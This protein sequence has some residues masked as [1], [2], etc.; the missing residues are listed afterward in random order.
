ME[1]KIT[2][3]KVNQKLLKKVIFGLFPES[4][5]I[6]F[7]NNKTTIKRKGLFSKKHTIN[8][9]EL[10]L[11]SIPNGLNNLSKS[12]DY[13]EIYPYFS[14]IDDSAEYFSG[15]EDIIEELYSTYSTLRLSQTL[16]NEFSEEIHEVPN[17]EIVQ[18]KKTKKIF[19]AAISNY[20]ERIEEV[21]ETSEQ[22]LK[23]VHRLNNSEVRGPPDQFIITTQKV[24]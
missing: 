16:N 3:S 7:R 18:S 17:M 10:V 4:R 23:I 9:A 19:I 15:V 8:I 13:G 11:L 2:L 5:K 6:K 1:I 12:I 22:P 14:N 21:I 20:L 24:A